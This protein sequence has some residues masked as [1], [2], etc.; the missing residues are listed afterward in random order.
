MSKCN[1]HHRGSSSQRW[2]HGD[3][4]FHSQNSAVQEHY[5]GVG[6]FGVFLAHRKSIVIVKDRK[7]EGFF[8]WRE[9][10]RCIFPS[11]T[12][13]AGTWT[14]GT[15]SSPGVFRWGGC[16]PSGKLWEITCSPVWNRLTAVPTIIISCQKAATDIGVLPKLFSENELYLGLCYK[17]HQVL[18]RSSSL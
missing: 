3:S 6:I 8:S 18:V 17:Q 7:M 14:V 11:C 12:H 13:S 15:F 5:L 2:A 1:A 10:K 4:R 9:K 16:C